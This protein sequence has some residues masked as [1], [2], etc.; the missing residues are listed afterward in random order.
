MM[1]EKINFLFKLVSNEIREKLLLDEEALYSTTDQI[2]ANK[3]AKEINNYLDS[4][5]TI[6]DATA[7]IGGSSLALSQVFKKVYAIEYNE[8]RFSYL[9]N[10]MKNLNLQNVQCIHGDSLEVCLKIQQDA[11]FLDCPWGGP[12]YKESKKVMLYLTEIPLYDILRILIKSAKLFI[13]KIPINFDEETFLEKTG[14]ILKLEQKIR[15]RKMNL[16]I[17]SSIQPHHHPIQSISSS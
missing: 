15:L 6:T 7:C 1:M 17:F 13:I 16:M 10:N 3:I 8:L 14:D 9:Q 5:A 4:D 12:S 11:I 2:T